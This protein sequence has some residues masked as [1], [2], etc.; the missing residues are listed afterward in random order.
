MAWVLSD[1]GS[2]DFLEKGF[3]GQ[4]GGWYCCG[5]GLLMRGTPP[6]EPGGYISGGTPAACVLSNRDG[7]C[8]GPKPEK[9]TWYQWHCHA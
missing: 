6:V 5:R 3:A 9:G 8:S 7:I 4:V 2:G 1:G